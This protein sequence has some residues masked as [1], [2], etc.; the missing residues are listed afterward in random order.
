L[1]G[2][3]ESQ[4]T[5]ENNMENLEINSG[6]GAALRHKQTGTVS[7][8][9]YDRDD[10]DF[11]WNPDLKNARIFDSKK[12]LLRQL[13]LLTVRPDIEDIFVFTSRLKYDDYVIVVDLDR[14]ILEAELEELEDRVVALRLKLAEK[15]NTND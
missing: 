7:Y 10:D 15:S 14:A 13:S 9:M 11:C 2:I 5:K 12:V 4:T 3:Q 1:I 8:L 6:Y